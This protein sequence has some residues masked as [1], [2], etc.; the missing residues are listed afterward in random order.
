MINENENMS[1][2]SVTAI[3]KSGNK[4]KAVKLQKSGAT[5][6]VL[7]TKSSE[8]N[9]LNWQDFATQ[10]GLSIEPTIEVEP[11]DRKPVVVGYDSAGTA[12]SM[13]AG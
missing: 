12:F 5:I 4:L 11:E 7:Q 6:E 10:C 2:K 3:A 8:E 13:A 1:E 9:I